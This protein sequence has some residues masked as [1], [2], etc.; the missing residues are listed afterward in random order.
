MQTNRQSFGQFLSY[1]IKPIPIKLDQNESYKKTQHDPIV[2]SID[3]LAGLFTNYCLPYRLSPVILAL[4]GLLLN[5][6]LFL[7]TYTS[8]RLERYHYVLWLISRYLTY[9]FDMIDGKQARRNK[10]QSLA[11]HYWDHWCD[12]MNIAMSTMTLIRIYPEDFKYRIP[13]T[14]LVSMTPMGFYVNFFRYYCTGQLIE[15]YT[16][17]LWHYVYVLCLSAPVIVFD[18]EIP[19]NIDF[20]VMLAT[21]SAVYTIVYIMEFIEYII[22]ISRSPLFSIKLFL[23]IFLPTFIWISVYVIVIINQTTIDC[24]TEQIIFRCFAIFILS[25]HA[26]NVHYQQLINE[27]AHFLTIDS[28]IFIFSLFVLTIND[29]HCRLILLSILLTFLLSAYFIR[30]IVRLRTFIDKH[31]DMGFPLLI[32][33][34]DNMK[35]IDNI[36]N[37]NK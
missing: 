24:P 32:V 14:V 11:R 28:F 17:H 15:P 35:N 3:Y 29:C 10:S 37:G 36:T 25:N 9:F 13:S 21:L 18:T 5:T 2:N 8:I 1:Q 27:S 20:Q 26:I 16:L 19:M 4:P 33:T 7:S 6:I 30:L 31:P 12:T 23:M 34:K 22:S